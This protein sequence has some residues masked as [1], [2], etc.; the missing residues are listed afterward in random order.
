MPAPAF[1]LRSRPRSY[2]PD[3]ISARAT[4]WSCCSSGRRLSAEEVSRLVLT[5][6]RREALGHT[7]KKS[8]TRREQRRAFV[9]PVLTRPVCV[10]GAIPAAPAHA[11]ARCDAELVGVHVALV[12][13]P[14]AR[15]VWQSAVSVA[16]FLKETPPCGLRRHG[17]AVLSLKENVT[18]AKQ[19]LLRAREA[20]DA[21]QNITHARIRV[22]E[23]PA[24]SNMITVRHRIC[25]TLACTR[26]E[27]Y[28]RSFHERETKSRTAKTRALARE[29]FAR[30][31][32]RV[33]RG[34]HP[35][36]PPPPPPSHR[37]LRENHPGARRATPPRRTGPRTRG[38]ER[39]ETLKHRD[40]RNRGATKTFPRT[41]RRRRTARASRSRQRRTRRRTPRRRRARA[42]RKGM[43]GRTPCPS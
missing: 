20:H 12:L 39:P 27:W 17:S 35:L 7:R 38:N 16:V 25:L 19:A 15:A 30:L 14:R 42:S 37:L 34:A 9:Q 24:E 23:T 40:L 3:K 33:A 5:R 2:V 11:G 28:R 41:P 43:R 6:A 31:S 13:C 32:R 36:T 4:W 29:R 21:V 8:A 22:N 18:A 26:T 1:A 10:D